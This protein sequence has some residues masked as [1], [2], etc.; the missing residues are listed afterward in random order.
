MNAAAP[1]N[2]P[3]D[4]RSDTTGAGRAFVLAA[5]VHAAL[6][7]FLYFGV[8]WQ[9]STP[10]VP[11]VELW[12][13]VPGAPA[14][15]KPAPVV[16]TP[17]PPPVPVEAPKEPE[18]PPVKADIRVKEPDAPKKPPPKAPAKEIHKDP[19][20]EVKK[21]P[22]KKDP[23][24][25]VK[26]EPPPKDLFKEQLERD[27][28]QLNQLSMADAASKELA[29]RGNPASNAAQASWIDQI[30][31]RIRNSFTFVQ[32][33]PGNPSA[34]F[35]VRLFPS[36]EIRSLTRTR[37]TG[38]AALDGA[39]ESAIRNAVPFPRAPDSMSERDRSELKIRLNLADLKK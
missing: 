20:K 5:I 11:V 26:K 38:N 27:Q 22:P 35:E 17:P 9:N 19:P 30:R 39:M 21:E 29:S 16:V 7:V 31:Q 33:M 14:A 24:K 15:P 1:M 4:P 25:E 10:E 18:P 3:F 37:S 8:S 6:F 13:E 34:E 23:P 2:M 32:D 12:G 28:R 36:G